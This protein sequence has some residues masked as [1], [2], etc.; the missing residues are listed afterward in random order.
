M[1]LE[2]HYY[3]IYFL[4][5]EAGFSE[6]ESQIISYSSQYV[7]NNL[8]SRKIKVDDTYYKTIPTQNYGWWDDYFPKNVYLPFH[9][10]PGD[11]DH[12][13]AQRKDRKKNNLSCTPGS[14]RVRQLLT[15][16]LTTRN[17]YRVGIAL[18]TYADSWAHQNFSGVDEEWNVC[19]KGSLIPSIGHAQV[20]T[21][22]DGLTGQ[23]E[24]AR[25]TAGNTKVINADR[26]FSAARMIYKFL[27][28]YNKLGFD[29]HDIIIEKLK[30]T[31]G[32]DNYL[33]SSTNDRIYSYIIDEN[34]LKYDK[35]EWY[36]EAV[37]DNEIDSGDADGFV[38]YDKFLWLKDAILHRTQFAQ[39]PVYKARDGFFD[40]HYYKWNEAAKAHLA[41]AKK[42]INNESS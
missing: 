37:Y 11:P 28:T 5:K 2:F 23:W 27:R 31:T 24:D 36:K 20:L 8:I 4:C 41:D 19:D 29:D 3:I 33:Q 17:L 10:F 6:T 35:Y 18:H 42:I 30:W 16:G 15:A 9:F 22:P 26:F 40:T 12:G 13:Q 1:N 34:L 38:G 25:L 21:K 14:G 39:K 32:I 7:D